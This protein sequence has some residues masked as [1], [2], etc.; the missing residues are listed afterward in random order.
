MKTL[1]TFCAV[2]IG[3]FTTPV[4]A[5]DRPNI[6]LIMADDVSRD[7]IGCYGAKHKTPNIDRLASQGLRFNTA[8]SM[9][10][11]TPT[12]VTL[13]TGQYPF[14]HGWTK[15]YDVPRW[16]GEGLS[17]KKF[18]TFA[19]VLRDAGYAT[20]IGGKWQI[21]NLRE[22]PRALHNHGFDEHCIWTGMEAG[23][24]ETGLR[25]FKGHILTNGKR[26]TADYGPDT[27]NAFLIDFIGRHKTKPFLVYYPMLLTHGPHGANPTNRDKPPKSKADFFAD[28]VDY[29]DKLVGQ[30]VAAV[31]DLGLRKNTLIVFTTDN[32]SSVAGS[33]EL[34]VGKQA[35]SI[36]HI[37]KIEGYPKGKG[38]LTDIG[39]H[40]PLIVRAP[41]LIRE[42]GTY[43]RDLVDFTDFFPT[44]AELAEAELP[45]TAKID[46]KSFVPSLRGQE[47]PFLKRNWIFAQFGNQRMIR[48]WNYLYYSDERLYGISFDPKQRADLLKV[49]HNDKIAPSAHTRLSTILNRFPKKD[50]AAPFSEYEKRHASE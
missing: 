16:G 20:A 3:L 14:H 2:F 26:T 40:V 32:G 50:A 12:R 4:F 10:I 49:K 48:D 42:P 6:I 13:L 15:H 1:F 33:I 23:H 28:N 38:R 43:T 5:K 34:T 39:V 25:Y 21:S 18:T 46:G 36:S 37:P 45:K 29:M 8:W 7:W 30:L 11:C 41:F 35:K 9:P 22:Q 24:P 19:R 27:I 47:D 31:D 44:F 17:S